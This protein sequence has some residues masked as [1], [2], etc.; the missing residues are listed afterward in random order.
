M[1]SAIVF[2]SLMLLLFLAGGAAV[3]MGVFKSHR[4]EKGSGY[5]VLTGMG[6][7]G[8]SALFWFFCYSHHYLGW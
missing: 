5:N 8:L 4:K 3:H 2:V 1:F 7:Y 6:S